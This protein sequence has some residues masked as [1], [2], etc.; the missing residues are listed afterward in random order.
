MMWTRTR[1]MEV[2]STSTWFTR[3]SAPSVRF[4]FKDENAMKG[5][6]LIF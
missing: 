2:Y 1:M 4:Y 6:G 3:M 5:T